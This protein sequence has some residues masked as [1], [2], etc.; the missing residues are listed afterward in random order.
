[1]S[2]CLG[3]HICQIAWVYTHAVQ[4]KHCLGHG[5][6]ASRLRAPDHSSIR[7]RA[8]E[9][10]PLLEVIRGLRPAATGPLRDCYCEVRGWVSE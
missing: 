6:G 2:D 7:R 1:M 9:L 10:A 8:S 3:V 5:A 4:V